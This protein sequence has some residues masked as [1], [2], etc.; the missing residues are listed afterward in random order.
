MSYHDQDT[1]EFQHELSLA[2]Y[3]FLLD[4][5]FQPCTHNLLLYDSEHQIHVYCMKKRHWQRLKLLKMIM[6]QEDYVVYPTVI[7]VLSPDRIIKWKF[8]IAAD[9]FYLRLDQMVQ[10]LHGYIILKVF[11]ILIAG[12]LLRLQ[13]L[14][15]F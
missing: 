1:L 13:H 2:K 11:V 6:Q 8:L 10:R 9:D 15:Y 12:M 4:L 14:L 3:D 7:F 5:K